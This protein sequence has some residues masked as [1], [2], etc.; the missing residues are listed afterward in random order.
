MIDI[1]LMNEFSIWIRDNN[2][3][4]CVFDNYSPIVDDLAEWYNEDFRDR[5]Y[6]FSELFQMFLKSREAW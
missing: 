4:Q 2:W 3:K 6:L 5:T 1:E